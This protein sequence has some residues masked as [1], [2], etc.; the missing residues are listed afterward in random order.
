MLAAHSERAVEYG[1]CLPECE[2][3]LPLSSMGGWKLGLRA[4][5]NGAAARRSRSA[6]TRGG[7]GGLWMRDSR[8]PASVVAKFWIAACNFRSRFGH[9]RRAQ[10]GNAWRASSYFPLEKYT[11]NTTGT[12]WW[13]G[14]GGPPGAPNLGTLWSILAPPSLPVS[15][16]IPAAPSPP[17]LPDQYRSLRGPRPRL[18]SPPSSPHSPFHY[19]T[20]TSAHLLPTAPHQ[21]PTRPV[22]R[23][24][25]PSC[26]YA[27]RSSYARI[28]ACTSLPEIFQCHAISRGCCVSTIL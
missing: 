10:N 13:K 15:F 17:P 9:A 20:P 25:S 5:W 1:L 28:R 26:S 24:C 19:L 21:P 27:T 18:R 23:Y 2:T 3:G 7:V 16:R 11:G 4:G 22:P 6:I 8:I 12:R 14:F